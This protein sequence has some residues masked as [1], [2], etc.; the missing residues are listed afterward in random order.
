MK[1]ILTWVAVLFLIGLYGFVEIGVLEKKG[2]R[3]R[4]HILGVWLIVVIVLLVLK[5]WEVI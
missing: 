5:I 3:L 4:W 2:I 1:Y